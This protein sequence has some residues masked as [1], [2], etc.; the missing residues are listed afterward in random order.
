MTNSNIQTL[1]ELDAAECYRSVS[2]QDRP[3]NNVNYLFHK[4]VC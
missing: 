3:M 4:K 1:K 2:K